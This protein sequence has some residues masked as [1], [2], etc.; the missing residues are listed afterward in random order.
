[1]TLSLE[2]KAQTCHM[3]EPEIAKHL[4]LNKSENKKLF[5]KFQRGSATLY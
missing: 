2:H 3:P 1:M 4:L 5:F